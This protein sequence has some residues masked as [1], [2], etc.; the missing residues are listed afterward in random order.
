MAEE[1]NVFEVNTDYAVNK[2]IN[3]WQ[4]D[5]NFDSN[6]KILEVFFKKALTEN[7]RY[8]IMEHAL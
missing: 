7:R 4:F 8:Y 3:G 6:I 1:Q 5:S 2:R